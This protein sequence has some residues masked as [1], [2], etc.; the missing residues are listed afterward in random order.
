MKKIYMLWL[1]VCAL[2]SVA[3]CNKIED[4][5]EQRDD[6]YLLLLDAEDLSGMQEKTAPYVL[7]AND[8]LNWPTSYRGVTITYVS[9]SPEII[10][11]DGT[12]MHPDECWIESRDQ[13]GEINEEFV[14]LNDNWPVVI[15]VTLAFE[16]QTRTAKLLYVVAPSDGYTCDKYLG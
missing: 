11:H 2:F 15:D 16:G 8:S 5:E 9:R 7:T 3:A 13:Q 1:L 6:I 12:I 4:P 10:G 14:G